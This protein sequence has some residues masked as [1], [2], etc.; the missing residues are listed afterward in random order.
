MPKYLFPKKLSRKVSLSGK[1]IFALGF[2]KS[3]THLYNQGKITW[4]DNL[5][6]RSNLFQI[7]VSNS[8]KGLCYFVPEV[9]SF[10][11]LEKWNIKI[12]L[13]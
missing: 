6:D 11:E 9:K 1:Q 4:T 12:F 13:S 3:Y 10:N 2:P 7:D 5:I 8:L